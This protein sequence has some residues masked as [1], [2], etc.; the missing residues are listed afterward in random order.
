MCREAP[1]QSGGELQHDICE[2]DLTKAVP[3][4]LEK[5]NA[6]SEQVNLLK[7][8]V[9]ESERR[10]QRGFQHVRKLYKELRTEQGDAALDIAKPYFAAETAVKAAALRVRREAERFATVSARPEDFEETPHECEEAY[11]KALRQYCR[12]EDDMKACQKCMANGVGTAVRKLTL[13]RLRQLHNLQLR[14]HAE[15]RRVEKL[16]LE[17]KA[18]KDAYQASMCELERISDSIHDLRRAGA[19]AAEELN[20]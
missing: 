2:E 12:A 16:R 18:A 6:A 4:L 14:L 1:V 10:Q 13:P 7:H 17:S 20:L 19:Y 5:M 9:A 8:A 15:Q 11:A 3:Q